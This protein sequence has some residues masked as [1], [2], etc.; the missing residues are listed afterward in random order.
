MSSDRAGKIKIS[1][2]VTRMKYMYVRQQTIDLIFN[3]N[4]LIRSHESVQFAKD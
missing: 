1:N 3:H 2:G 4:A